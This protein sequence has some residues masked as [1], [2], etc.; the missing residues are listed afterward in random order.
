MPRF[1]LLVAVLLLSQLLLVGCGPSATTTPAPAVRVCWPQD[2]ES[3]NPVALPNAFAMQLNNLL[4]QSLLVVDG[5]QRRY[6]PWLA[7]ALPRVQVQD[8]LTRLSYRLR[9]QATWDNGQPITGRDVLFT[10]RALRCPGLPNELLSNMVGFIDEVQLDSTDARRFTFVCRGAAPEYRTSSGDFPILPEYLLD[11]QHLL[12]QVPLAGLTDSVLAPAQQA[13]VR[14]FARQFNDPL[15]WRRPD[16]V[17]GSGPYEL[18]SWQAGQRLVLRRKA[19][20]WADGLQPAEPKLLAHPARLEFHIIPDPATALLA[21]RRGDVDLY[22]NM[23]AADFDKLRTSPQAGEF[24]LY[25]PPSYRMVVLEMNTRQPLLRQPATRQ[26]LLHLLDV[27]QLI[28]ATQYGLGQRSVGL[29]SPNER[30]AY[31]DS[32][33][34]RRYDPGRAA[35]LLR[36]AGWQRARPNQW[37]RPTDQAQLALKVHYRAGDRL[38]ETAALLLQQNAAQ[39]GIPLQLQ[40]TEA[41]V[42]SELRRNGQHELVLR[43]VYGNPFAYDLRPLLHT[44]SI[45]VAGGNTSGFG[46]ATSDRVLEE[47]VAAQDSA[48]KARLLRRLQLIMH[49]AAALNVLYYEPNRLAVTKRLINLQPAGLEPGY[50]LTTLRAAAPGS[51]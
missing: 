43:K 12:R 48:R 46:S 20:W 1:V 16:Q 37:Q 47:I 31:H 14:E 26:A 39:L 45:G 24:Q 38:M 32:L 35:E 27:P 19:R 33:P 3:L 21:L 49:E 29:V 22:P 41:S 40:P 2:P 50:D 23:A 7:E 44:A 34:L 8:S 17:R 30:W 36:V 42:L 28:E 9:P 13:A 4:Y 15:R 18:V 25:S 51:K 6:V 5:P 11:P 10:L